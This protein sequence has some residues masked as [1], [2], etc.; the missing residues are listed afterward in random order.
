LPR[1]YA[2]FCADPLNPRAVDPEFRAEVEAA[3]AQGFEPVHLDHDQLDHR[4]DARAALAA[5]RLGEP[6]AGVY[7]GW[8]ISSAAYASLF[9]ALLRRGVRLLTSP[10]AYTACHHAP[11]SLV[12]LSKWMAK[13]RWVEAAHL[14]DPAAI[15][16]ALEPFGHAPLVLKDWVKSQASGYWAEACYISDASD[17]A[18][19]RRVVARFRELQG[20][21]FVGGLVFKAYLPLRPAGAPSHEYRA[22][23]IG[24]RPVGCWPRSAGAALLPVPPDAL[25]QEVAA[26]LP[27][28]FASMDFGVDDGDRWWLLEVGDGQVSG[29]PVPTS[30]GPVFAA[31]ASFIAA[32]D[33]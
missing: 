16:A 32:H 30:A 12:A 9:D 21:S 17:A 15:R 19:V 13:T 4:V 7:R 22:F 28:P 6:G 3:N 8:M 18:Q 11:G 25:L 1:P 10:A 5:C 29:F 33:A 14:D 27:S 20:E 24:G 2:I 26:A 23:A 31:L